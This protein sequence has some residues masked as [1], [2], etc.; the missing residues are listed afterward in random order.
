MPQAVGIVALGVLG[1]GSS[2]AVGLEFLGISLA[3]A[4]GGSI[5]LGGAVALNYG[6][7]AGATKAS[8]TYYDYGTASTATS[9]SKDQATF[10]QATAP[11]VRLYGRGFLAGPRACFESTNGELYL[12]ILLCDGPIDAFEA[13]YVGDTE[14]STSS[15]AAGGT[16]QTEP[17]KTGGL[18]PSWD[19]TTAIDLESHVGTASQSASTL[20]TTGISALWTSDHKLSGIAYL[21]AHFIY[22]CSENYQNLFP[23]TYY[24]PI[25]AVCRGALLWDPRDDSTAWS[26]NLGLEILDYI[27]HADGLNQSTDWINIESFKNYA[28]KCDNDITL[29]G[30]GTIKRYTGHGTYTFA[31]DPADVLNRMCLAGDAELYEDADGKIAIRGGTYIAPEIKIERKH[32]YSIDITQGSDQLSAYNEIVT[33]YID[34]DNAYQSVEAQAWIDQGAQDEQGRLVEQLGIEMVNNH[35]QARRISKIKMARDNPKWIGTIV[36]DL[37]GLALIQ[38]HDDPSAM[39][40]FAFSIPE[41]GIDEDVDTFVVT[42]L[43]LD[44]PLITVGCRSIDSAAWD[45]DAETEEGTA[46][47]TPS[48]SSSPDIP[49]PTISSYYHTGV[50]GD[51]IAH[52]A[53]ST[54]SRVL[55]VEMQ[56]QAVGSSGWMLC[57]PE[58][59][60]GGVSGILW[61]GQAWYFRA[62]FVT[63]T[64][65]PGPWSGYL[66]SST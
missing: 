62:R 45:W 40:T 42:S 10:N 59:H 1:I 16:V 12:A 24:T 66:S 63:A 8:S 2:A 26:D 50:G 27:K 48:A 46:P 49:T 11:R 32:I 54:P 9:A 53:V 29:K 39:P 7:A 34:P 37:T 56:Y 55:A 33:T 21:A 36:T 30:G 51:F 5:L 22:V 6:L 47:S 19:A 18:T 58:G 4:V 44:F 25:R 65:V 15:G 3:S 20:L 17:W 64:G 52:A 28:S 38:P 57:A 43:S 60:Y 61:Q 13:F 41:L 14:V 31:E 35:S 23:Q